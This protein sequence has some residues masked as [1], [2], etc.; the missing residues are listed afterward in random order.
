M[1]RSRSRPS[2][3]Y[4]RAQK[5]EAYD[6]LEGVSFVRSFVSREKEK[7]G[8]CVMR[9]LYSKGVEEPRAEREEACG[10]SMN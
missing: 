9:S 3:V 6:E 1:R 2:R 7:K 10:S 8:A 5:H 4:D